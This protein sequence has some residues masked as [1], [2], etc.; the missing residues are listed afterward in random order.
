LTLAL[1]EP[2]KKNE[3]KNIL[4]AIIINAK[5]RENDKHPIGD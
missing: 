3:K 5:V 2:K 4:F 1:G